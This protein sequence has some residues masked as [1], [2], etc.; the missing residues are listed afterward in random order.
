MSNFLIMEVV[1]NTVAGILN[2][3]IVD[4]QAMFR[5]GLKTNLLSFKKEMPMLVTEAATVEMALQK[6][7]QNPPNFVIMDSRF[8]C[9]S[10]AELASRMLRY[11]PQL[12]ILALSNCCD[13][14]AVEEMMNAGALGFVSKTILPQQLL[15]AIHTILEGKNYY[16]NDV[17]LVLLAEV[18]VNASSKKIAHYKLTRREVE[19]MSLFVEGLNNVQVAEKL[20]LS[21]RTIDTHK[22]NLYSKLNVKNTTSLV[23]F[24]M[25]LRMIK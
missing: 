15:L 21:K 14:K 1:D 24:A 18:Q 12:K 2:V 4:E 8:N 16:C 9:M 11:L 25:E 10:G 23:K 22:Q 20:F 5:C 17:A 19:V 3:L 13:Q 7:V 6:M